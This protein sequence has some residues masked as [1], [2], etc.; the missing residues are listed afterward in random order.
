MEIQK[1]SFS[2]QQNFKG[3]HV[4]DTKAQKSLLTSLNSK[5]LNTLSGYVK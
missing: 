3:F 1:Q 4:L 2:S 5:Q